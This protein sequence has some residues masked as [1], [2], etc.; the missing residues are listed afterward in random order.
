MQFTKL[1]SSILD[2]TIWQEPSETKIVWIT[3]LAMVDRNGEVQASIPGLAARA[4]VTLEQCETS[5]A[6][7][8]APDKYSRTQEHEGRRIQTIE[9]GWLMLNHAK[10]RALLSVEERREYNRRKQAEY[11]AKAKAKADNDVND[12]NTQVIDNVSNAHSTEA[13]AEAEAETDSR[14]KTKGDVP[15]NPQGG[16]PKAKVLPDGWKSW[17]LRKRKSTRVECNNKLMQRVGKLFGRK[18]DTLWTVD[19]AGKLSEL[20]PTPHEID[21]LEKYYLLIIDADD[22]YRR[23]DL[24]TLLNNWTGEVD[25]A[26]TW[27]ASTE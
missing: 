19:E 12:T 20:K 3:M 2:S 13:E 23:R 8:L 22:D 15:P 11:R 1:F 24:P 14:E 18:P 4:K 7:F 9:G 21:S 27:K 26:T 16:M 17:T 25:R 5:L 10:Y 6:S